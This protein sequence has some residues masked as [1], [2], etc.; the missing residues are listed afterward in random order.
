M[1]AAE[2][3][4]GT[5]GD[6]Y[7]ALEAG[8]TTLYEGDFKSAK[9]QFESIIRE[10]PKELEVLARVRAWLLV[11]ERN[12]SNGHDPVLPESPEGLYNLAVYHHNNGDFGKAIAALERSLSRGGDRFHYVHYGLAAAHARLGNRDAALECLGTAVQLSPDVRHLASQD[13]DFS[14]LHGLDPFDNLLG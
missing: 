7:S 10:F 8:I 13:S 14:A 9:Q 3:A 4:S 6:I 12:L 5:S 2:K 11:C 1:A